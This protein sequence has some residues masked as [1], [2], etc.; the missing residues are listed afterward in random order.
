MRMRWLLRFLRTLAGSAA[1]VLALGPVAMAS[2]GPGAINWWH[3]NMHRPPVGWFLLD[4]AIFVAVLVRFVRRPLSE[5]LARRHN[6]IAQAIAEN[7]AVYRAAKTE[8]EETRGKLAAVEREV[9]QLIAR[10]K[11][12]GTQ[13]R[14]RIVESARAYAQRLR[15]DSKNIIAFEAVAATERLRRGVAEQALKLAYRQL[16]DTMNDADRSRMI[17][18]AIGEIEKVE[19]LVMAQR[20]RAA[21]RTAAGGVE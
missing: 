12:D 15:E 2:E 18:E 9:M 10:V 14:D 1:I 11:E 17:D 16:L 4:F 19:S 21:E 3:W 20:R 7:E 5:A 13:E 6:A 8:Y